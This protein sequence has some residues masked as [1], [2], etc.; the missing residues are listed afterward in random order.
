GSNV[1]FGPLWEVDSEQWWRDVTINLRGPALCAA[2]V[3][4]T[5]AAR[6]RGCIVNIASGSAK[7]PFS[8]NSSYA[9]SKAAVVRFT[10]SLAGETA[11]LG[12]AVFALNPGTV[13]THMCRGLIESPEGRRWMP[14]TIRALPE[15]YVA[16]SVPADAVVFLAEG[17]A[18]EL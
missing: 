17:H 15:L 9:A 5:M 16:P 8:Y 3:I 10:D 6:G 12:I 1:V 13:E 7:R 2:A 11:A 14:D 18:D 4:P